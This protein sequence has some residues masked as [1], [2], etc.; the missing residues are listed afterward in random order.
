MADKRPARVFRFGLFEA[1]LGNRRLFKNGLSVGLRG[2][3]FD[4]LALLL[5][6]PGQ[7]VT[8]EQLRARLWPSGTVVE[9]DHGIHVAVTK[10]REA[11]G[12][13]TEQPRLIETVPR[14]GY[15][16]IA[17][18]TSPGPTPAES[19]A[20]PARPPAPQP[21][22][23]PLR[24][25]SRMLARAL[26]A[27]SVLL[28][29]AAGLVI[30]KLWTSGYPRAPQSAASSTADSSV[31]AAASA[32]G[33]AFNPP[34]H[35]IAVL[36]FVNL[37]GDKQQEYFSDGLTEELLNALASVPELQVAAQT[38]SFYFKGKDVD[39]GTI[40]R[41]LNVGSVLEGSVRRSARTVRI[42]AQ[43]IDAV[44]GFH[45]WSK[46]YDRDPG[47][48]LRL[49]TEVATD[50]ATALKVALLADVSA[51]I[52]LGGTGNPLAF[53]AYLRGLKAYN[54]YHTFDDLQTAISAFTEAIRLD[55]NYA[56]AFAKR[57]LAYAYYAEI[58]PEPE[59]RAS[60]D[61][62]HTDARQ[63]IALAPGLADGYH[64][65]GHVVQNGELD[66]TSAREPFE[67]ALTLA[68]GDAGVLRDYALY[69]FAV[70]HFDAGLAPARRGVLLDPLN[71]RTHA[72]LGYG[73]LA[74]H[75]YEEAIA[76]YSEAI[77]V[78]PDF[79]E[80]YAF[81]GI[82]YYKLGDLSNARSSCENRPD[83]WAIQWCLAIVY[84]KLGRPADA[85][86][87]LAKL[88]SEVDDAAAYQYAT[89]YTQWGD[90]AAAL[91]W[92]ETGLRVRDPGLGYLKTDP[93][94]EFLR[95]E[96]RARAVER[97]LKFPE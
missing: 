88:K 23:P 93:L 25:H 80:P 84:H 49:Q 27:A 15:R 10:L 14:H 24:P 37:S 40:A 51:R 60:F 19:P 52:E 34:P 33:P 86:A 82:A 31:H 74:A 26:I 3:P 39:L 21:P 85:Q 64:A 79:E 46:T 54:T 36:P 91:A 38:S 35:S 8:R 77:T 50:V 57:S 2:Q 71:P 45:T 4:V 61:R 55:P 29:I 41:R 72:N 94:M 76:V 17:P 70:G 69:T 6:H 59:V 22:A 81:R 75:R 48:V 13:D 62:A 5:E 42:T 53:D 83:Y 11:L 95:R 56:L 20:D 58:A 65:L 68:P 90:T 43:L 87:Q 12:E 1:D 73:L 7:L 89:I 66:Y 67:R 96:P 9:F 78:D 47:D 16:F 28:A 44:T 63:A 30:D 18:V 97:A 32:T 92:L